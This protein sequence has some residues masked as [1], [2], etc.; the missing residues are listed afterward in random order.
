MFSLDLLILSLPLF[1]GLYCELPDSIC[2]LSC[3]E[4]G[5]IGLEFCLAPCLYTQDLIEVWSNQRLLSRRQIVV[6]FYIAAS[7][8]FASLLVICFRLAGYEV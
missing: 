8:R 4:F 6:G 2:C 1:G 7:R 5:V 3:L